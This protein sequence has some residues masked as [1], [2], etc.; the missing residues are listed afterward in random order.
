[1]HW[2][3]KDTSKEEKT[4]SLYNPLNRFFF[5]FLHSSKV[6]KFWAIPILGCKLLPFSLG[7]Y[8]FSFLMI[9]YIANDLIEIPAMD[10]FQEH[11]KTFELFFYMQIVSDIFLVIG[12]VEGIYSS[13]GN[14]YIP[15]IVAY[16]SL[17]LSFILHSS[18]CIYT[19]FQLK[20]FK[21]KLEVVQTIIELITDFNWD[22]LLN[23]VFDIVDLIKKIFENS[24]KIL[25]VLERILIL[26]L[27]GEFFTI[28]L[29]LIYDYIMFYFT[30]FLFCNMIYIRRKRREITQNNKELKLNF[31]F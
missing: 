12:I 7:V 27:K 26:M 16:Y 15:S 8:I 23:F 9:L 6:E 25:L 28:I 13:C 17:I 11:D 30:W 4:D 19:I 21:I 1:M 24:L 2:D 29:W 14:K 3:L 18:F 5:I 31:N 10:Y 22:K 20:Q